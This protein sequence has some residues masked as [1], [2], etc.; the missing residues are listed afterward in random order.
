M[1][2]MRRRLTLLVLL[3]LLAGI[4]PATAAR[5][6]EDEAVD[7]LE[8]FARAPS[9]ESATGPDADLFR[10]G[11]EL[12][13]Q[14]KYRAARRLFWKLIDEHPASPF[15]PEANDRSSSNAFLGFRLMHEE[16]PSAR[17]IDV[18]LMGDGYTLD[19]QARF[20]KDAVGH[21]KVFLGEPVYDAYEPYFN[22]WRF[23]LASKDT[24]VDEVER[25]PVD[26]EEAERLARRRKKRPVREYLHRLGLQGG[27][28][29][30][31]GDGQSA[32]RLALPVV[33]GCE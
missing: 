6:E 25:V 7:P 33:S 16:R 29:P 10:R 9:L 30:G 27:R 26:E 18:A 32:P 13:R 19:K 21:L 23:N 1:G 24:G 11:I 14:G 3:A 22:F 17:R 20:D 15:A 5:G 8:G 31:T 2:T 28:S 4:A 12:Q